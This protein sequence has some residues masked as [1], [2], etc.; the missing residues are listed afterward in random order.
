MVKTEEILAAH[1]NCIKGKANSHDAIRFTLHLFENISC[2]T[3][4]INNRCYHPMPSIS[5]V[6]TKPVYREVFAADYRDR[7]IHHYIAIRLE[8]LFENVFNDRTYNCRKG[9]GQLYGVMQLKTDVIACSKNFTQPC[10]YL[11][12]DMKGFF[13]SIPRKKLA[14]KIDKFIVDNY[15]GEDKDDLRYLS[16]VTIMNDPLVGCRRK[17]PKWLMAKVPVGKSLETSEPEHGLPIGNLTSQHNANFW[18]SEFDWMIEKFLNINYHSRY[19][20]D[21]ILLSNDKN[22]LLNCIQPIR[23]YLKD[24]N[25][26]LHPKK[27]TIQDAYKGINFTGMVIKRDRLYIGNRTVGN[28]INLVHYIN[29]NINK[30]SLSDLK[31]YTCSL[32]SYLG[33]M[34]HCNNYAIRRKALS[35]L[36]DEF[37]RYVYIKGRFRCVRI[38]ERYRMK[39][40]AIK[41][42]KNKRNIDRV[43]FRYGETG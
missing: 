9:K 17:S 18:L 6:V 31:R 23:S 43:M 13:M 41:M 16:R 32:N 8:P 37:Y 36:N 20:D 40:V 34:C 4:D 26:T 39:N 3:D 42:L 24:M 7:V 11:K 14:D 1:Y 22:R 12:C 29:A 10:W 30:C 15:T 38:K 35:M 5:F 33:L 21:F 2:L 25:I 27:I 19:V 28:L